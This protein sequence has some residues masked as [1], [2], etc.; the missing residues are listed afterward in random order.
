MYALQQI[1]KKTSTLKLEFDQ[2]AVAAPLSRGVFPVTSDCTVEVI[3]TSKRPKSSASLDRKVALVEEQPRRP[4][5][6][7]PEAGVAV[8]VGHG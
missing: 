8:D 2:P 5:R 1:S 6:V 4:L 3:Q 7:G